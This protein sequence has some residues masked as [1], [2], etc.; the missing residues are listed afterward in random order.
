M[1]RTGGSFSE[2]ILQ[3]D[4]EP[5]P[6]TEL[7]FPS[8]KISD[9]IHTIHYHTM[10]SM[11]LEPREFGVHVEPAGYPGAKIFLPSSILR[12]ELTRNDHV[13]QHCKLPLIDGSDHKSLF[14]SA[15]LCTAA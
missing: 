11:H 15:Q 14:L 10:I 7:Q 2:D 12:K 6:G 13:F 8:E 3:V 4:I 5:L 9:I 1:P